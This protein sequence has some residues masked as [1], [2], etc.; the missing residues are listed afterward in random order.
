MKLSIKHQNLRRALFLQ[1]VEPRKA[2]SFLDAC[3]EIVSL[4]TNELLS[5][6]AEPHSVILVAHGG[7]EV[8]HV[9]SQ[10]HKVVVNHA[11]PG[12][13]L[14]D[15][16]VLG[17]TPNLC[18]CIALPNTVSLQCSSIQFREFAT[19]PEVIRNL[20]LIQAER[21]M[22]G[23]RFR[24]IDQFSSVRQRVGQ[25]ISH[26][27]RFSGK[28]THNQSYLAN[29]AG[30][31]R[32]TVNREIKALRDAGIVQ[33]RENGELQVDQAALKDWLQRMEEPR[34]ASERL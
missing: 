32:Q 34:A 28:V 31:T 20:A 30:C 18:S 9:T 23:I 4:S 10:G 21:L 7:V 27:S 1:D 2:N 14:G 13:L 6:G 24:E 17:R 3:K 12:D 16:E 15:V 29:L 5:E 25:Y 22:R 11:G 26:L 33:A 19:N 8:S